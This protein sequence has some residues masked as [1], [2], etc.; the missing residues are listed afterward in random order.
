MFVSLTSTCLVTF[1]G[2]ILTNYSSKYIKLKLVTAGIRMCYL[3]IHTEFNRRANPLKMQITANFVVLSVILHANV[4]N[5]LWICS[6]LIPLIVVL[7]LYYITCRIIE[8]EQFSDVIWILDH[9]EIT[10]NTVHGDIF[11]CATLRQRKKS[12]HNVRALWRGFLFV[13]LWFLTLL[14]RGKTMMH[15]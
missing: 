12:R 13:A 14:L 11:I 15:P 9:F 2:D 1:V 3:Y 8:T 7:F 4:K 6:T 10:C 5:Y